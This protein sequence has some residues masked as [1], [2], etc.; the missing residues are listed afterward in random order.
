L[1][2]EFDAELA[3]AESERAQ[4][5]VDIPADLLALYD[6]I[7]ERN[8]GIG[9]AKLEGKRCS[10]CQLEATPSA[11]THYRDAPADEVLRCEECDRILVR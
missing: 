4:L 8:G 2:A 5:T 9:A 10:G 3:A 6:R 11:L 7:R 1:I